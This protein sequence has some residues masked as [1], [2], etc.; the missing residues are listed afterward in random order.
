MSM[1]ACR[2]AE[3]VSPNVEVRIRLALVGQMSVR[4]GIVVGSLVGWMPGS[5]GGWLED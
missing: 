1:P 5:F 3:R 2:W 4:E